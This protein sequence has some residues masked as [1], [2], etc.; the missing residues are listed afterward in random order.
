MGLFDEKPDLSLFTR[1]S[2]S[3][4]VEELEKSLSNE[5]IY[6]GGRGASLESI[7]EREMKENYLRMLDG[8]DI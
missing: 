6:E 5:G 8:A 7:T 2:M 1:R 4:A 3:S